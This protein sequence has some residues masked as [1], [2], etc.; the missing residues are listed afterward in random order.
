MNLTIEKTL[1]SLANVLL[2]F[3]GILMVLMM[4][5][6]TLSVLG[7]YLISQPI[8]GTLEVVSSYYMVGVVF[9]PLAYVQR[10]RE[11]IVVELFTQKLSPRSLAG[12]EGV[13]Y[14]LSSLYVGM[15]AWRGFL[16]AFKAYDFGETWTTAYFDLI[17][18]PTYWFVPI[19]FTFMTLYLLLQGMNDL[20]MAWRNNQIA[21]PPAKHLP[22]E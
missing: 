16:S 6:I 11:H 22:I 1:N 15:L 21:P 19:G 2:L 9:F 13:I 3:G 18:W 10:Q 7:R 14:L 4:L 5:Q 17:T 12:L 8:P 20:V